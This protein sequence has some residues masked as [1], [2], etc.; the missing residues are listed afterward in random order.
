MDWTLI[1]LG[2]LGGT[3]TFADSINDVGQVVGS[4]RLG[5]DQG[6]HA[7]FYANGVMRDIAPINSGEIRAANRIGLNNLGHIASGLDTGGTYYPATYNPQN[8]QTTSLGSLGCMSGFCGVAT[9]INDLGVTVGYSYLSLGGPRHAFIYRNGAMTGSSRCAVWAE[10][11]SGDLM[12]RAG[13]RE[14]GNR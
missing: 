5:G 6:S 12:R 9:A 7:F 13:V 14:G 2:T 8:G 1:D 10:S 3:E 4:S 11:A